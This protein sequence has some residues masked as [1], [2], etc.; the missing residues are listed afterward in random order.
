MELEITVSL[1]D[2]S[3]IEGKLLKGKPLMNIEKE[4]R[5]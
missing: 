3:N 2:I 1:A 4:S 5:V